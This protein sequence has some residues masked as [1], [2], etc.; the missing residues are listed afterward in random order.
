[1]KHVMHAVAMGAA[2]LLVAATSGAAM[3]GKIP[4]LVVKG[5]LD[6]MVGHVQGAC[7][8]EDAIYLSHIACVFR[9]DW[10]G[11][12]IKHVKAERHTG[13]LC[14]HDGKVYSVL[15]KWG[16]GGKT[17]VCRLQVRDADLNFVAEKP[18]PELKGLDGV[19][20]LDGIIYHGV[21]YSSPV[22][23]SSHSL[24]RIDLKTLESL[25]Q[26]MFELPY[27][28]HFCQQNLTTD[29]KLIY[30]TFYPVKG[31]PYAL[32]ACDKDGK[33]VAHY[34]LHAGMGFE[35][36]PKGRFPGERPRFFKVN[37]RGGKQKDGSVK[38]YVVTLDFYEL[39][40]GQLR[41]ITKH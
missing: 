14:Y 32:T 30:M 3:E 17:K 11:N 21:G 26:V 24:G 39:A 1:M 13:D 4:R 9:L 41:D 10:D 19:T 20:V 2:V 18:L 35:R 15:G 33:L 34:D 28:T 40:D 38:P 5:P 23:R 27:Q 7:A 6:A 12:V 29:G 25:P 22:P 8:S 31:A 16:S 36:L 37:S